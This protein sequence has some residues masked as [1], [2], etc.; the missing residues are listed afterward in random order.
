MPDGLHKIEL[1]A[2][3]VGSI[4]CAS[5]RSPA[6]VANVVV[7]PSHSVVLTAPAP[8][9]VCT[10]SN[11]FVATFTYKATTPMGTATLI[12]SVTASDPRVSCTVVIRDG[13]ILQL[14]LASHG[15]SLLAS[16]YCRSTA[17][18]HEAPNN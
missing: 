6:A 17:S 9:P 14:A 13:E 5:M 10:G 15:G 8:V 11:S 4:G 1:I 7:Q 16:A 3:S 2:N 18:M 12:P